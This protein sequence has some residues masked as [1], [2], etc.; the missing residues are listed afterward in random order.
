MNA[1]IRKDAITQL[2]CC[3]VGFGAACVRKT[4]VRKNDVQKE[5]C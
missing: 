4:E 3:A 5:T 1:T 2:G